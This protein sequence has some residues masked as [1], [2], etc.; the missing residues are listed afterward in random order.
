MTRIPTLDPAAAG[1]ASGLAGPLADALADTGFCIVTGHGIDLA[2]IREV[3]RRVRELFALPPQTL[4]RDRVQRSNYRGYVPLGF[5]TPNDGGGSDMYAAW[6][7]HWEAPP[8][9]AA[10]SP[11][12]GPNRWPPVP[13]LR[14][15]VLRYW[16]A[17]DGLA[18]E[19]LRAAALGLGL[20]ADR[21]TRW[22]DAPLTNMTLLRYPETGKERW[23]IHPHKDFD[24]LTL[25]AHDPVGGLQVLGA[26]RRMARRGLSRGRLSGQRRRH[27]GAVERRPAP[28]RAASGP[29]PLRPGARLLPLVRRARARGHDRTF[30]APRAR[31]R[32]RAAE[33]R[34]G[35][36]RG[37]VFE[38]AGRRA[39]VRHRS[40]GVRRPSA[41]GRAGH[42]ARECR[43]RGDELNHR[44]PAEVERMTVGARRR[45]FRR[46]AWA[47][48][49]RIPYGEFARR[50]LGRTGAARKPRAHQTMRP[51]LYGP[52]R[53]MPAA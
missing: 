4:E 19:L 18:A 53:C 28:I 14:D 21:F 40:R 7:L 20:P 2:L 15:A 16:T 41:R 48:L 25:L 36:R 8:E 6:K 31:L 50:A 38:L 17:L 42:R 30:A 23:G 35:Q 9:L 1:G 22:F 51:G 39:A 10:R 46:K 3:R 13:G 26:R 11:L 27:A 33:L 52:E 32:P 37:V 24:V 45:P 34:R 47:E 29:E 12:Y 5:F 43:R 49:P 44:V